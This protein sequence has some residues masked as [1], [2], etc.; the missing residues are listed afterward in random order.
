MVQKEH[1]K[2]SKQSSQNERLRYVDLRL[3][4]LGSVRRQDVVSRFGLG[5]AA[6]TR[7][8]AEYKDLAPENMVY[9]ATDKS[10]RRG[11]HFGPLFT[12]VT[13]EEVLDFLSQALGHGTAF[14]LAPLLP[15]ET[16][17][18]KSRVENDILAVITLAIK[19]KTAVTI[20]YISTEAGRT[21]REILPHSLTESGDRWHVRAYDRKRDDFGDFVLGCIRRADPKLGP[22]FEKE[23]PSLDIQWNNIVQLELIA[24][25]N[26][27]K[28]PEALEAEFGTTQ[29][30]LRVTVRAALASYLLKRMSVDCSE[31]R[32]MRGP[33]YQWWLKNRQAL[34]GLPNLEL[35][36]GY[37]DGKG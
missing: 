36:P 21:V 6:A 24:H 25:P 4:F 26:N 17:V 3:R 29:G 8:M 2:L 32:K 9:Q 28:H 15:V 35:V 34:Y 33:A 22:V 13:P 14:E 11:E 18:V 5:T 37:I 23:M 19:S 27:V 1:R 31:K 12:W 20:E 30:V 7:D 16:P 10:Y